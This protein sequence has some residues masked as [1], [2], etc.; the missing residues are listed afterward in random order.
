M[1]KIL[2]ASATERPFQSCKA[3]ATLNDI[4]A[5]AATDAAGEGCNEPQIGIALVYTDAATARGYLRGKKAERS[6]VTLHLP[7]TVTKGSG[8]DEEEDE[9]A[10]A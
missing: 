1:I 6:E 9:A 8:S 4:R 10:G 5:K 3:C 2:V 7:G